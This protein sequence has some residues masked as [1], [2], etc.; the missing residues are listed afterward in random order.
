MQ[1]VVVARELSSEPY[2]LIASQPTRGID[3]G[4]TEF[5]RE[6]LVVNRTE[7]T[8]VLLVSADLSEV[9]SLSD[10]IITLY[11]GKVTGVFPD[12][13]KVSEEELGTYML[14]MNSKPLKKWR[15]SYESISENKRVSGIF[16]GSSC[17]GDRIKPGIHPH[18]FCFKGS[19]NS[20][21]AFL[22]GPFSQLN[23][24]GDWL[25]ESITLVFLGLAVAIVFSARQFYIGVEGQMLLAALVAGT[26]AIVCTLP[27]GYPHRSGFCR[28]VGDGIHL[29]RHSGLRE[30]V[31]Q[32]E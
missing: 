32:R 14:G 6:Q 3:V 20:Y 1:K 15:S 12:A 21:K 23:R 27:T 8:A 5:I 25:E 22:F 11:E 16:E 31:S 28:W 29:G 9:M 4:A 30:S 26:V 24:I 10:R 17:F 2:I 7:G 18:L 13:S 19:L